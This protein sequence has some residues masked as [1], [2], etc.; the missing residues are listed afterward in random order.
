MTRF[1]RNAQVAARLHSIRLA[2]FA[3]SPPSVPELVIA[4]ELLNTLDERLATEDG[5]L[6][7]GDDLLVTAGDV[8]AAAGDVFVMAGMVLVAIA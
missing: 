1:M 7:A 3:E 2:S 8:L 5:M 4:V 6:V